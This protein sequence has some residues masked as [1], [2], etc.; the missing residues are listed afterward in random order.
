MKLAKE[1]VNYLE[2]WLIAVILAYLAIITALQVFM[3][4]VVGDSLSWSEETL[5]FAFI[6]MIM[7]G[8]SAGVRRDTHIRVLLVFDRLSGR[9]RYVVQMLVHIFF[10]ITAAIIFYLSMLSVDSFVEFPQVSP[11]TGISMQYVYLAAPVG[12]GLTMI[13]LAQRMV[14]DTRSFRRDG[15][16]PDAKG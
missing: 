13:R 11:A 5:R 4:H 10:F 12:F 14:I 16:R 6:W 1:F 9:A 8:F 3:R 2:E 7:L 15:Q